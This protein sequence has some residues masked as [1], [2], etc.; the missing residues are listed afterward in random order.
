MQGS[1]KRLDYLVSAEQLKEMLVLG[2][3]KVFDCATHL[4]PDPEVGYSVRSGRSDFEESH[5]PGAQFID[6]QGELSDPA[7]KYRFTM[8]SAEKFSELMAAKG[9]SNSDAVVIY[10]SNHP[11]WACRLWWM[12]RAFGHQQ[13]KVLDGGLAAWL[14]Q[15]YEVSSGISDLVPGSFQALL[16][17]SKVAQVAD[18]LGGLN[19]G[20]V[21]VINALSEKQHRGEGPHYGRPGR[22]TGSV[23]ASWNRFLDKDQ[24]FL[25]NADLLEVLTDVGAMQA[26]QI[27]TY[28]GG[29]IAAS[30][31][32]LAMALLGRENQVSLYDNSLSE[33]ANNDDLPMTSDT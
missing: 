12:F 21:C 31:P 15:G 18:I 27:I 30:V 8:P 28:C 16:D 32:I 3:A 13:V 26:E 29:G 23:S 1:D 7:S 22:I 10:A 14:K 17:P 19:Q 33:W 25:P 2:A 6:L 4:V 24:F 20:N 11:M 5:I 9:L